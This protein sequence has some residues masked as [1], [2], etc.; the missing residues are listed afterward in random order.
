MPD[1]AAGPPAGHHF[2]RPP[3]YGTMTRM[4][5]RFTLRQAIIIS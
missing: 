2:R 5:P 1:M 4:T 3:R